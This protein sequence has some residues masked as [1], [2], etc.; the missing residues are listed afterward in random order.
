[1]TFALLLA[2]MVVMVSCNAA[3]YASAAPASSTQYWIT[4]PVDHFG[5]AGG[6]TWQQQY[7]VNATFYRPGGPIYVSTP[8]ESPVSA[9]YIDRSHFTSLAQRTNGLLVTIEHR[10]FGV[11]NP[12]PD[13]SGANLRFLT[14]E[15]V[16]ADFAAFLRV[17]KRAPSSVFPVPVA[18]NARVIFG[19][20][21]YSGNVAAWMRA[22]YPDLV[23]GAWASSAIVYG[24]LQNYQFDQSFGR[25][26]GQLGC[27]QRVSQAV[28]DVDAILLSKNATQLARLQSDF[29]IPALS[30]S[31][32]AG[33]LAALITVYSMTP[34]TA[35]GDYVR[36]RV[37][38][39]FDNASIRAIDA[40]AAAVREAIQQTGLTQQALIQMG[41]SSLNIDNYALGQVNRVWYYMSCAWFGNWQI[42]PPRETGLKGYRSQLVNM[43]YFQTNCQ[44][45]F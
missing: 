44:K 15:N 19:G 40:Y 22:K 45:K 6:A 34:I 31:D 2:A 13:L 8:G 43:A 21:S 10:Y 1:T 25:R 42:A 16:L 37:C 24:R 11:S 12:M 7:L 14:I 32:S 5:G 41:D 9:R 17:A 38:S 36:S 28:S 20:G 30:P 18:A 39:F 3:V 29:G 4:Q 33:L 26:L 27:A 35:T 23:L